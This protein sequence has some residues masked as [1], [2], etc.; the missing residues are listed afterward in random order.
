MDQFRL[1]MNFYEFSKSLAIIY[2]LKSISIFNY[3]ISWVSRLGVNY[4]T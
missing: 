3:L 4:R 1:N 2:T